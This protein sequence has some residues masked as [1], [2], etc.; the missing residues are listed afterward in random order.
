MPKKSE[1]TR[2]MENIL[3]AEPVYIKES[4]I[5]VVVTDIDHHK[6]AKAIFCKIDFIDVPSKKV[7]LKCENFSIDVRDV[8]LPVSLNSPA[9]AKQ[10]KISSN[11]VINMD[12][13]STTPYETKA[14]RI[15]YKK[16]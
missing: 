6:G 12:H 14:A 4:G 5:K 16:S 1:F 9:P 3:K 8:S 11:A 15:L 10:Y 7:L 13:L 2:V